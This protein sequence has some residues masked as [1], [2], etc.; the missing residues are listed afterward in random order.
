MKCPRCGERALS[1]GRWLLNISFWR[2]KCANCGTRL[3]S[4]DF[5]VVTHVLALVYGFGLL[6]LM[7]VAYGNGM[8]GPTGVILLFLVAGVIV[9]LPFDYLVWRH[10]RRFYRVAGPEEADGD[11]SPS[12]GRRSFIILAG[13]I[14]IVLVI[15]GLLVALPINNT[16]EYWGFRRIAG[17]LSMVDSVGTLLI[18]FAAILWYGLLWRKIDKKAY[19]AIRSDTL[20]LATTILASVAYLWLWW[21]CSQYMGANTERAA[22]ALLAVAMP[23]I[24]YYLILLARRTYRRWREPGAQST[25]RL[26]RNLLVA[27]ASLGG[28]VA[29]VVLLGY[30]L[31]VR[32]MLQLRD[33]DRNASIE[34]VREAYHRVIRIPGGHHDA[35]ITLGHMGD[36]TSVPRLISSLRWAPSSEGG[37]MVCTWVHCFDALRAIT[38]QDAGW[39]RAAWREWYAANRHKTRLEWIADGFTAGGTNA[40]TSPTEPNIRE[41]LAFLGQGEY[42]VCSQPDFQLRNVRVLLESYGDEIVQRVIDNIAQSGTPEE[43]RGALRYLA[44]WR[45]GGGLPLYAFDGTP[46]LTKEAIALA[47]SL[48]EDSDRTVRLIA[49]GLLL[50]GL[51]EQHTETSGDRINVGM[52]I[53]RGVV[54][55]EGVL[56]LSMR[57]GALLAYSTAD[58]KRL[59]CFKGHTGK[60]VGLWKFAMHRGRIY[61]MLKGDNLSCI[62]ARTG[63]QLWRTSLEREDLRFGL[64]PPLPCGDEYVAMSARERKERCKS[65][66]VLFSTRDGTEVGQIE[67]ELLG[68]CG[69]T[70]VTRVSRNIRATSPH[71]L[72][73]PVEFAAG[74]NVM[75]LG[76]A[77]DTLVTVLTNHW[78]WKGQ[79][80]GGATVW[81]KGWSLASGREVYSTAPFSAD[82]GYDSRVV[83]GTDGT[84][85]VFT[86][87]L[88]RA[89]DPNNGRTIWETPLG[90]KPSDVGRRLAI[91]DRKAINVLDA[92]DGTLEAYFRPQDA[93]CFGRNVFVVGD[94]ILALDSDGTLFIF[95]MPKR[96]APAANH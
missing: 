49:N 17:P 1:Y 34:E 96:D 64:D 67:G 68:V 71:D 89:F 95:A 51:R 70:I 36:E 55:Q 47:S 2:L 30:L 78:H 59:W 52:A 41:L 28:I 82:L 3:R 62:D 54:S 40:T 63:D 66:V 84:T 75:G 22:I 42:G 29:I 38:N 77:G 76:R 8:L 74:G 7:S 35:F 33:L 88:T 31:V 37:S 58:R 61:C 87:Y 46:G 9:P 39:T 72:A 25:R 57:S 93:D 56:Y 91:A 10:G 4:G 20:V 27:G 19:P 48:R 73:A 83:Q 80:S 92:R 32:P 18:F 16:V 65:Y 90:G 53:G 69:T 26:R 15:A 21:L 94:Q 5:L 44:D 81:V 43:K 50:P 79:S 24:N 86:N 23:T 14:G 45:Y 11:K 13:F 12:P 85:Y 6:F 60:R